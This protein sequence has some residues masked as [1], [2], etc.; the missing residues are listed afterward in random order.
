MQQEKGQKQ[1]NT[2]TH[3][4]RTPKEPKAIDTKCR[5][6]QTEQEE[7]Q[8]TGTRTLM[9]SA[10]RRKETEPGT[11]VCMKEMAQQR[12]QMGRHRK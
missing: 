8:A 10:G 1:Q 3:E 7:Q 4:P 5:R 12:K 9:L 6:S 11:N 2:R